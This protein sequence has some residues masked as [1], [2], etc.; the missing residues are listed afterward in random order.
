MLARVAALMGVLVAA[1]AAEDEIP[2]PVP[3]PLPLPLPLP[4]VAE[5]TTGPGRA[6]PAEPAGPRALHLVWAD[7]N[8]SLLVVAE[9]RGLRRPAWVVTEYEG[10]FAVAYAANAFLDDTGR[11]HID[12]RRATLRG[13]MHDQWIPDSF[14]VSGERVVVLDDRGQGG[15]ARVERTVEPKADRQAFARVLAGARALAEGYL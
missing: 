2:L 8:R 11:L 12:G 4:P 3:M 10:E 7:G 13:P 14:A 9:G 6:V 1:V 5:P 15:V